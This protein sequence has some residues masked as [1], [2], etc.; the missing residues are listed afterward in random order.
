MNLEQLEKKLKFQ[1]PDTIGAYYIEKCRFY[2]TEKT[3]LLLLTNAHT[4]IKEIELSS[5]TVNQAHMS[6]REIYVH[7]LRYEAVNI[8]LIHNHPSGCPEPS[9]ADIASTKRI[10]EAGNIINIHLSDHIIVAGN[11]YVSMLERGIL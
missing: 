3:F 5:G 4:L 8:I 7:A 6:P 11:R 2:N 9:E 1:T 10:E